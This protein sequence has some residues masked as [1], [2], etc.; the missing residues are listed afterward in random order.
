MTYVSPNEI[1]ANLTFPEDMRDSR[2]RYR[3]YNP[4]G[5]F[6]RIKDPSQQEI[7]F[8]FNVRKPFAHFAFFDVHDR[9]PNAVYFN[10]LWSHDWA[11]LF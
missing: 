5:K 8:D 6:V 3:L 9:I 2:I 11:A 1:R 4:D 7:H 10:G